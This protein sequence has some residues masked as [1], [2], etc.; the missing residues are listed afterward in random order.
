[1]A[2][3]KQTNQLINTVV[4]KKQK[5]TNQSSINTVVTNLYSSDEDEEDEPPRKKVSASANNPPPPD[6]TN[7]SKKFKPNTQSQTET[8]SSNDDPVITPSGSDTDSEDNLPEELEEKEKI[9]SILHETKVGCSIKEALTAPWEGV[10]NVERELVGCCESLEDNFFSN[11]NKTVAFIK[12]IKGLS[13]ENKRSRVAMARA[14]GIPIT[15]FQAQADRFKVKLSD[16][17]PKKYETAEEFITAIKE[18]STENKRSRVA[19]AKAAGIKITTFQAQADRFKVKL[20]DFLPKKY[21]TA[22]EFLP[23][24]YETAEEFI[25]AIKG[26][27]S[28][29]RL[30]KK[31]MANAMGLTF[32]ALSYYTKKS[33]VKWSDFKFNRPTDLVAK[34]QATAGYNMLT[35]LNKDGTKLETGNHPTVD[36]INNFRNKLK[37]SA[38]IQVQSRQN[39]LDTLTPKLSSV[40]SDD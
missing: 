37:D 11:D 25:T 6:A 16:F 2:K 1:M 35:K 24:K 15:T 30:T 13:T 27:P 5:Q 22:E 20:S 3:R 39:T 38:L 23:K 12:V 17:L 34:K 31:A 21:E 32:Y 4:R 26:L 9:E 8:E 10:S 19:M 33:D 40:V 14:A 36:G 7:Q 29:D 18:L 28:E